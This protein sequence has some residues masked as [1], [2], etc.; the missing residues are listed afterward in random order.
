MFPVTT[1]I[2]LHKRT[3]RRGCGSVTISSDA[4][5]VVCIRASQLLDEKKTLKVGYL[6][7]RLDHPTGVDGAVIEEI[8]EFKEGSYL[9]RGV[10]LNYEVI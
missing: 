4:L 1:L 8:V 2:D 6:F 9:Y 5:L 7:A 10:L 3:A